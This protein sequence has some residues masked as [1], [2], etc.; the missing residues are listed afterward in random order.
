[1][2]VIDHN[3]SEYTLLNLVT[4]DQMKIHVSL[5]KPF[6][7][8]PAKVDPLE[9]AMYDTQEYFIEKVLEHRGNIKRLSS[10]EFLVKWRGYGLEHNS[11]EPW[12][13]LRNAEQLHDYLYNNN[14]KKLIPKTYID[15]TKNRNHK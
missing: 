12:S 14:M 11:W 13:A 8:D 1:M 2:R 4:K 5:L 10:M 9:I 7:Y 6:I 15:E 3:G